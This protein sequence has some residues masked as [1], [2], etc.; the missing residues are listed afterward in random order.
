MFRPAHCSLIFFVL[1]KGKEKNPFLFFSFS[2]QQKCSR[3]NKEKMGKRG[4]ERE[5][6]RKRMMLA[7]PQLR[8]DPGGSSE[9]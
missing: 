2:L 3:E 7:K 6:A 9:G 5:A 8:P 1:K 4:I